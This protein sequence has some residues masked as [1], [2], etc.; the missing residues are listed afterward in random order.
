[1]YFDLCAFY[2]N[3]KLKCIFPFNKLVLRHSILIMSAFCCGSHQSHNI[4]WQVNTHAS[5]SLFCINWCANRTTTKSTIKECY[6][7]KI[8]YQE[9][10]TESKQL[11]S[12]VV[13]VSRSMQ[14]AKR[15][16]KVTFIV[17]IIVYD[18]IVWIFQLKTI[19]IFD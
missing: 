16:A 12:F 13:F 9:R 7:N 14:I 5:I 10:A 8:F 6:N 3:S 17:A 19:N 4:K 2:L 15:S 18:E 11:K 1:M